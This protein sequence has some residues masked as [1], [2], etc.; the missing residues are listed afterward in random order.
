MVTAAKIVVVTGKLVPAL[1][2][3]IVGVEVSTVLLF[4]RPAERVIHPCQIR[5]IG[6]VMI[7]DPVVVADPARMFA[8]EGSAGVVVTV[9]AM[10]TGCVAWKNVPETGCVTADP[11]T[12]R[13]FA[14]R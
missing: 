7:V 13:A 6:I 10:L 4:V 5:L 1:T 3:V 12:F 14:A 2:M 8:V 11:S 9:A